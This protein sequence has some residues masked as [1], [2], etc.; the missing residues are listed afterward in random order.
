MKKSTSHL[1][2]LAT[3]LIY[4]LVA[5][6]AAC[7]PN[8]TPTDQKPV[9]F[10][11]NNV[12][13][14]TGS[15]FLPA[16][17]GRD[18]FLPLAL[19]ASGLLFI[20]L[21]AGLWN[22]SLRK[23][24]RSRTRALIESEEKYWT[25][26]NEAPIGIFYYDKKGVIVECNEKFVGIIGSSREALIGLDMINRLSNQKI[27]EAVKDSL[28]KGSA[29]YEGWYSSVTAKRKSFVRVLFQRVRNQ[30][31]K[32]IAGIALIEDITDRKRT[33]EA[34]AKSEQ[35]YKT[36]FQGAADAIFIMKEDRFIE[37]NEKTLD[38]FGCEKPG[39]I[40]GKNP[41]NFSPPQQPDG[42]CS[43]EKAK[44]FVEAALK[45]D[46]QRFYWQHS[47]K[48]G[49]P[50]DAE[51]NLNPLV[52]DG[53]KYLQAIV[54]DITDRRQA[55]EALRQSEENLRITLNSIGDAVIAADLEGYIVR[56]NPAAE[57]ITGWSFREAVGKPV[58]EVFN[59]INGQTREPAADPVKQVL[60]TG[61]VVGLAN[62]TLLIAKDKNEY[63]ISDSAAPIL[64]AQGK[65]T[66]VVLVF[67]NV[68]EKYAMEERLRQSQKMEAVGLLAGG[69][70][71]DFNNMLGG[72]RGAAELIMTNSPQDE[73]NGTFLSMIIES[74]DRASDLA[75]K[76][77]SFAR[78][79]PSEN[80]PVDVHR[81]I[82]K[83]VSIMSSTL[84]RRIHIE[85]DLSAPRSTVNGDEAQLQSVFLNL[86]I[87]ASHA[88]PKGGA[89]SICSECLEL[90]DEYCHACQF[91][92]NP[93]GYIDL[94][95]CD[96]GCGIPSRDLSHIFEPFFTTK[97]QGEG[98]GLGLAAVYGAVRQHKGVVK[99]YSQ[100][101]EGSCFHVLLP[102]T[103]KAADT[104]PE[105]A[106]AVIPGKGLVLLVD[107]E[108]IIR[109]AG[110][111]M[112]MKLGYTVLLAENGRK[113][114]EVFSRNKE[115]IALV[116]IDMIMPEMN[117]REC[118][119]ALR[120]MSPEIP[121]LLASGFTKDE[122]LQE[123][124][125][126][127]LNGFIKKPYSISKISRIIADIL[128]RNIS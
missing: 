107:D 33:E 73:K 26:I 110:Q 62:H 40:L 77:L 121:V 30:K 51:V 44:Q 113:A 94:T 103:E 88:M 84:D 24:L 68:T 96:T 61:V 48:S 58:S 5:M 19:T 56:M 12:F 97:Q 20:C 120:K 13:G 86:G 128:G 99:V 49:S 11:Q 111:G 98:T 118:F 43:K 8:N 92:L 31:N 54:R 22:A 81:V 59:I 109:V 91:D 34:L 105:P 78:R 1:L 64:N 72:I 3:L 90:T 27:I 55:E 106:E 42:A 35:R 87:N 119:Y 112:L 52:M 17:P 101:G 25:I 29:Y 65:T 28:S 116:I 85:L 104:L 117:G 60:T 10:Q 123:L 79:K 63:Q 67:Q 21:L 14:R 89:L 93:G 45:G 127:G 9:S 23:R 39:D 37:C 122:D 69:I 57:E 2:L 50:F 115:E 32:A 4:L 125:A 16:A 15:R 6:P 108:Q 46:V 70:A 124:K 76:L 74:V 38:I 80:R 102:L 95:V 41:W 126:A 114:L 75:G 36:L 71:H 66:G 53:E 47:K 82:N 7:A 18:Y 83:A 100:Q